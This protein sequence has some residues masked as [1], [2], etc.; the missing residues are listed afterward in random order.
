MEVVPA[1]EFNFP[2][3]EYTHDEALLVLLVGSSR[4]KL[5]E[6]LEPYKLAQWYADAQAEAA[7]AAA[8]GRRVPAIGGAA[9]VAAAAA[10]ATQPGAATAAAPLR[11]DN[12]TKFVG[13]SRIANSKHLSA[14]I[15]GALWAE[16]R[17]CCWLW[18]Q[19]ACMAARSGRTPKLA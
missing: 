8:A 6:H 12:S 19:L 3:A 7:A 9:A 15:T 17:L 5:E 13:V 1:A 2:P 14:A 11:R 18:T 16:E 10:A 4:Q